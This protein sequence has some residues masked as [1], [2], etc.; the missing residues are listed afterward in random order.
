MTTATL[1]PLSTAAVYGR[2]C[3]TR[4]K[5]HTGL[6]M[7]CLD[8]EA[9]DAARYDYRTMGAVSDRAGS[10]DIGPDRTGTAPEPA[11]QKPGWG[12]WLEVPGVVLS[13]PIAALVLR[14]RLMAPSILPDPSMH[15]I[16][17]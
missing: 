13:P 12:R 8:S 14:L 5:G 1:L 15:S 7:T 16:Y 6:V 17:I 4:S 10:L 3:Q 11:R 2:H 9:G